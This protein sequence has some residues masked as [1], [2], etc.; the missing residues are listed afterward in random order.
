M[1][2]PKNLKGGKNMKSSKCNR[3][4]RA[5]KNPVYI[6]L[7]YGKVCAAKMGISLPSKKSASD[8]EEPARNQGPQVL[9]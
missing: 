7:G 2:K 6:E 4:G 8:A 9:S 1:E 3:C 5:L